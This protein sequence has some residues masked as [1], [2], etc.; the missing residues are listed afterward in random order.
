MEATYDALAAHG[1]ADLTIQ[2]IADEFPK[3][4]SLLYYHYDDKDAILR[5]FLAYLIDEFHAAFEADVA[6]DDPRAALEE[7]LSQLLPREFDAE[8]RAFRTAIFELQA[9]AAHDEEYA[10]R[11]ADLYAAIES[12]LVTVVEDGIDAGEFQEVD[13]DATARLLLA[14]T[15][16]GLTWTLTTDQAVGP[17]VHEA[18]DAYLERDLYH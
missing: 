13:P 16:G 17:A 10:A 8:E 14:I 1:Y 9:R 2:A 11:F 18:I 5:D 15:S 4:K 7:L 6:D 12:V 3:S